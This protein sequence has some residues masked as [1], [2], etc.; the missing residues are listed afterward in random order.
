MTFEQLLEWS[1]REGPTYAAQFWTIPVG[2][3]VLF[4]CGRYH[5]NTPA[6]SLDLGENASSTIPP[7]RIVIPTPPIFTTRR[8][9][10]NHYAYRYILILE[11]AFLFIVFF[12]DIVAGIGK[13]AKL[14]LPDLSTQSV[15]YRVVFA[16]F[17]LTGLFSSFP[18]LKDIDA[19]L[20]KKLHDA[21][22]IPA[23]ARDL[24]NR[25]YSSRFTP[26]D[27]TM[28][29]VKLGLPMRDTIRV[30][31]HQAHGALEASVI[32]L[33]C[34]RVQ[35][36]TNIGRHR[37]KQ[38]RIA[39]DADLR[40]VLKQT[41]EL[42]TALKSLLLDQARMVPADCPDIDAFILSQSDDRAFAELDAR[43][44]K[45]HATCD[46][47][48]QT[49]CL[50]IALSLFATEYTAEKIDAAIEAMGFRT[51]TAVLPPLDW[52]AI[53][54]VTIST[55]VLMLIFNGLFILV[56]NSLGL[57]QAAFTRTLILRFA[58]V[59]TLGYA[60][61]MWIA[62]NLKRRWAHND[63]LAHSGHPQNFILAICC[64]VCTLPFN[65]LI[66][67]MIRGQFTYAPF[68]YAVNQAIFG[69]FVGKYIDNA[70]NGKVYTGLA[71]AQGLCHGIGIV[72]ATVYS[73]PLVAL[74]VPQTTMLAAISFVQAFASGA[75]VSVLFQYFYMRNSRQ[76]KHASHPAVGRT[77]DAAH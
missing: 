67:Y 63:M 33:F 76:P 25:L 10:Y 32:D 59:Y 39:L 11:V 27:S 14:P 3:V 72:I 73:T 71:V 17:A 13:V 47:L 6:Y 66:G 68:L 55:F 15:E 26:S 1:A 29:A 2:M 9:R 49:F 40:A 35:V 57:N 7:T 65:I 58:L 51:E 56:S 60:V 43:R 64:Y 8:S 16:L 21:A 46:T 34:L 20:L 75:I 18:V 44:R 61:V 41:D 54:F 4:F 31:N 22:L 45:L 70:N 24:A 50:L 5:F 52:D 62:I 53:G 38:F 69:Y 30:A 23:D 74:T 77:L 48:H 42:Q 28:N 19:W 36:Q 12:G 37:F